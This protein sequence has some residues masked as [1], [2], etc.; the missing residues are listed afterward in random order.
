MAK[1]NFKKVD[2]ITGHYLRELR[3]KKMC[4][5]EGTDAD[6]P[7]PAAARDVVAANILRHLKNLAYQEHREFYATLPIKKK[8]LTKM[9]ELPDKL[10]TEEWKIVMEIHDKVKAYRALIKATLDPEINLEQ[11]RNE[12]AKHITKRFNVSDR[13]LPEK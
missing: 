4:Q 13:W 5:E 12:Q 6:T 10:S 8:D 9:L 2:D 7:A 11:I 1:I 3:I